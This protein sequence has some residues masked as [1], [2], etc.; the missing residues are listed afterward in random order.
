VIVCVLIPRFSLR[1]ALGEAGLPV[2]EPI[3]LAPEVGREQNIGER[4]V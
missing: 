3:A 4:F 2:G 1:G